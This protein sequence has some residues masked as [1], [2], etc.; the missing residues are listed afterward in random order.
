MTTS[1]SPRDYE[2]SKGVIM[3]KGFAVALV[4]IGTLVALN[5][6]FYG[7][8]HTNQAL[9]MLRQIGYSFGY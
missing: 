3:L 4:C 5:H 7:G 1:G 6:E 9:R 8:I 2:V